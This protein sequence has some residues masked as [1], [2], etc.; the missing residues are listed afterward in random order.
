MRNLSRWSLSIFLWLAI[1]AFG[2]AQYDAMRWPTFPYDP[3]AQWQQTQPSIRK[4]VGIARLYPTKYPPE[5]KTF[6]STILSTLTQ[7]GIPWINVSPYQYDQSETWITYNPVNPQNLIAGANDGRGMSGPYHMFAF[8]STDGGFTWQQ[9]QLPTVAG[10][11]IE[12]PFHATNFDPCVAFNTKGWA[13][14]SFGFTQI[15]SQ[16]GQFEDN[17]IFVCRS[18][19]GGAS[20]ELLEPVTLNID[21][22]PFDDKYL[23]TIDISPNSP[24]KDNIYIV[25]TRFGAGQSG[26][27]FVRSTDDGESWS[28][29]KRLHSSGSFQSPVPVVAPDGRLYVFWRSQT[30]LGQTHAMVRVSTDGGATW[31]AKR[32][33]QTVYTTGQR[34]SQSNRYVLP[35]K[36]NLRVSS[37]PAAAVD[38]S[39]KFHGRV[40]VVQSGK[41]EFD[42]PEGIFLTYSDDGGKTWASSIRVD[43][44]TIGTDVFFPAIAVDPK[45]GIV[46]ILYYSS[47]NDPNNKGVDAILALS[48]D[49][50]QTFRHIRLTPYTAYLD[51]PN[52]VSFQ[53]QAGNYYWGDYTG[54]TAYGGTFYPCYWFPDPNADYNYYSLDVYTNIVSLAPKPV[55]N[56]QAFPSITEPNTITLQWEDPTVNIIGSPLDTF[57]IH[58]S[59]YDGI[60][61]E[62]V[63]LAMVPPGVEQYVDTQAVDGHPYSYNVW[64]TIPEGFQSAIV[65]VD[66]TAGGALQPFPPTNVVAKPHDNGVL[67]QWVNPQYHIDST[68]FYDFAQ[69]RIYQYDPQQDSSWLLETLDAAQLQWTAGAPASVVLDVPTEQFYWFKL[70]AVGKRGDQLTE[71]WLTPAVFSYAGAPLTQ[72]AEN[73]DGPSLTPYYTNGN[74]GLTSIKA[75]SPPNCI[76]DSPDGNYG[77]RERSELI[78]AP[79]IVTPPNTT[80]SFAHISLID[81]VGDVGMVYVSNDFGKSWIPLMGTDRNRAPDKFDSTIAEAQWLEEHRDLS[82]FA[83]DTLYLRFIL[84]TNA[85]R[86]DDGWYIDDIRIDNATTVA[87]ASQPLLG[88]TIAPNP[89]RENLTLS[90]RLLHT[91]PVTVEISDALGRRVLTRSLGTLPRGAHSVNLSLHALSAGSYYLYLR[92]GNDL[93]TLPIIKVQ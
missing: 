8:Y 92:T 54:I 48:E 67:L 19:D 1:A 36:Q 81:P 93:K 79:F 49:G 55:S 68:E 35:D 4:P 38:F 12:V 52:D 11:Y 21:A 10:E 57:T 72:F 66:V 60:T 34:H 25:W 80:L 84:I 43:N 30:S 74:W 87:E 83:G 27:Y 6:R 37:Y 63:Q 41:Q 16:Q 39:N 70:S 22:G 26:I 3:Q 31:G 89:V 91:A 14:Y 20:W 73:F 58:I 2:W 17:G 62:V 69:I 7:D 9:A 45:T 75:L 53:G 59:R 5:A 18:T 24:H 85:I 86:N 61:K 76:T 78:F 46:A 32:I 51:D 56:L 13:Y 64:V 44:N 77:R 90:F 23:M 71:S 15:S 82:A 29:P 40:Y 33:A 28:V 42:G 50:G 88:V 65:S 47:E